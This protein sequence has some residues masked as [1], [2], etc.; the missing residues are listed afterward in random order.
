MH[1]ARC[2][3]SCS[4]GLAARPAVTSR[5]ITRPWPCTPRRT[6]RLKEI[7]R[8]HS[9]LFN[10]KR[11]TH[12][13]SRAPHPVALGLVVKTDLHDFA[14]CTPRMIPVKPSTHQRN[15]LVTG[16]AGFI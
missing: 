13:D 7:E 9:N 11:S 14:P 5:R 10:T 15:C 16:G 6:T 12:D 4:T 8:R 1:D 3:V 2:W